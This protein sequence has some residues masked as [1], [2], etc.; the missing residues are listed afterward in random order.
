MICE[1]Y[2]SASFAWIGN[3]VRLHRRVGR[4]VHDAPESQST[5]LKLRK[6]QLRNCFQYGDNSAVQCIRLSIDPVFEVDQ[7]ASMQPAGTQALQRPSDYPGTSLEY[8]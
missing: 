4:I 1:Y 2:L 8:G 3:V 5:V 7:Y 6:W